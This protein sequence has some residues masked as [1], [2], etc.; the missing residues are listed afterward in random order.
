MFK[1]KRRRLRPFFFN[2]RKEKKRVGSHSSSPRNY[3]S[4]FIYL[5]LCNRFCV[6][7]AGTTVLKWDLIFFI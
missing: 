2:K 5:L 1:E 6:G 7:G 3:A 4:R